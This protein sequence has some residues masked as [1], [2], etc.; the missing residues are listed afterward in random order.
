[1]QSSNPVFARSAE[2][3]G[4]GTQT[5][6]DPSQWQI[7]VNGSPTHTELGRGTGRMT[8]DTV[9]EKT[10]ITLGVLVAT[11]AVW[12][13]ETRAWTVSV[14]KLPPDFVRGA[15]AASW[16]AIGMRFF[17]PSPARSRA[18]RAR[19]VVLVA[20][21]GEQRVI[22]VQASGAHT[23][24]LMADFTN[25]EPVTLSPV[26]AGFERSFTLPAGSHRVVVRIDGTT[27]RP[28]TNTPA[29]DDDLGGRVG[30]LVVP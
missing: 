14:S 21:T 6:N 30:L 29:V 4:K 26:A 25:W 22:R 9:V 12:F 1:M 27:W 3:N 16:L 24:E 7:D 28:P 17:E 2:F 10:A 5:Y 11:A 23:V 20:G 18:E 15:D 8:I 13:G 19:P